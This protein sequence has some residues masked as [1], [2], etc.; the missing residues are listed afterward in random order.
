MASFIYTART[1]DN[2][3]QNG[4]ITA[5]DRTAAIKALVEHRLTPVLVKE[6]KEKKGTIHL[7]KL[8]F[9]GKKV[10]TKDIVIMTRQL[11]TMINAGV[12]IVRSL[13]TLQLQTESEPLKVVMTKVIAMVEDGTALS[14]AL[15][16]H[17][18]VFNTVYVNMVRAGEAGGIL[19][20][21]LDRLAYQLEKDHDMKGKIK[22]AMIYPGVIMCITF[23]AFIFLMTGIVPKLKD[24]FDEFHAE[25]PLNT[26]VMLFLSNIFVKYGWLLAILFV[27]GIFLLIRLFR[28]PK[29]KQQL[30]RLILKFP[31]VGQMVLKINV[32]RFSRTFSSLT[33]AGVSVLDGLNVTADALGNVV[34]KKRLKEAVEKVRNGQ[35]IS[36]SIDEAKVFPP[37]VAQMIA[38]GEETGQV[39]QVLGKVADFYEKEVDRVVSSLTSILEPFLIVFLGG[40]VGVIIAS[41]FGPISNLTNVVQ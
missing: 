30:H 24:I 11:A 12:P 3:M 14:E 39:D 10:K 20:K 7:N 34:I 6:V 21:I 40:L 17:P 37:I 8:P 22:G 28:K 26:R 19:D 31:I 2:H 32:A 35:P 27:I 1:A 38:V 9:L 23:G 25:L 36:A 4:S 18:K 16:A 15:A 5:A 41:V 13:Q 33:A 29:P